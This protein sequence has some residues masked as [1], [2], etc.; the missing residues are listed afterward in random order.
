[1]ASEHG[2]IAAVT[3][4]RRAGE[5]PCEPCKVAWNTYQREYK[6]AHPE[7]RPRELEYQAAR[8]RAL[9]RLR[10]EFP[11]RFNELFAE[12]KRAGGQT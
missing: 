1:M 5:T 8:S 12:E 9:Q 10:R 2:T 6:A 4:H 3:R 11:R 7:N